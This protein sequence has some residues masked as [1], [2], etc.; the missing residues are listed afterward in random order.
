MNRIALI[1]AL[2]SELR[3]LVHHWPRHGKISTGRIGNVDAVALASGMGESAVTRACEAVLADGTCDTLVSIGYA[4]S[5]SCGLRA[6]DA[7]AVSEIVD[8]R[9]GETFTATHPAAQPAG[10]LKPQRLVTLDHVANPEE[11]RRLAETHQATL[12]DMEAATVARFAQTH[13]LGFLCF[14]A[15]TDGPNDELPDF[16][17]FTTSDGRLRTRAFAA[18]ALVHP[19]YWRIL[20]E[21]EKNS[22]AAARELAKFITANFASPSPLAS[23]S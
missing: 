19:R 23:V 10:G 7:V 8:A 2:P 17:R 18:W 20:S 22:H 1:A 15:I 13:N 16:N 21:L 5:L 14:K 4:G 11:K 6:P 3:P 12:V 9:T